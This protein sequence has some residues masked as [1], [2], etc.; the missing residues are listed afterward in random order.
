MEEEQQLPVKVQRFESECKQM[1]TV[2]DYTGMRRLLDMLLTLTMTYVSA[3][4]ALELCLTVHTAL[5]NHRTISMMMPLPPL[6]LPRLTL[7]QHLI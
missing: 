4:P 7:L 3:F 5:M 2:G 1:S 6:S